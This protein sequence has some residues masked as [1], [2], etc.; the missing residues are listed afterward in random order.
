[1]AEKFYA[2]KRGHTEGIFTVWEECKLSVDGFPGAEYKSFKTKREAENYL[3]T[4]SR[5]PSDME[6]AHEEHLVAY[7]DG[8]YE[9]SLKKYGFGCVFILPDGRIYTEKGSGDNPE[10]AQLRNV[11]GEMLGAM[12]AVRW[13]MKNGF[14]KIEL[15]YDYEGVEKWVTG[16]WR[17][18]T[19]LTGKYAEAMRRWGQTVEILFTKVAAHTNVH[20][21]ELAD[22][23]A[24]D[25]VA[26]SNG[27]PPICPAEE[28]ELWKR[29][30]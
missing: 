1:M 16:A 17:A 2:V 27:I 15:R 25:G 29:P 18:K 23:L 10:S 30:D 26:N 9:H 3:G 13:A 22:Q 6:E 24:K 20:Y 5:N 14:S 7:V 8:S 19:E 11:T 28:M 4:G 12:F 21:N